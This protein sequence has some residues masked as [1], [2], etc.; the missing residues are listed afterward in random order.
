MTT[1]IP[2]ALSG[3]QLR[4][5]RLVVRNQAIA[6]LETIGAERSVHVDALQELF[7]LSE[8]M[9]AL[10][11]VDYPFASPWRPDGAACLD[12]A[13]TELLITAARREDGLS[14]DAAE[15][16]WEGDEPGVP[17]AQARLR[18][19]AANARR[20]LAA[21]GAEPGNQQDLE[22]PASQ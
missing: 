21:L 22:R 7:P 17:E 20:L 3:E 8:L 13:Q 10:G 12:E 19:R 16:N 15:N 11:P 14:R 9:V 5:A 6:K 2:A 18:E 4:L 1:I